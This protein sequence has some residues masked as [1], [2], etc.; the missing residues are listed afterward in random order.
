MIKGACVDLNDEEGKKMAG[1]W[2]SPPHDKFVVATDTM[3]TGQLVVLTC[4]CRCGC[5]CWCSFLSH[6]NSNDE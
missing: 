4:R 3:V 1:T 6:G 2:H 5:R